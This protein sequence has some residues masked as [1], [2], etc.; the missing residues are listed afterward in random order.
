M[1]QESKSANFPQVYIIGPDALQNH[2][3]ALCIEKELA[4]ECQCFCDLTTMECVVTEPGRTCIL[5]LDCSGHDIAALDKKLETIAAMQTATF[6]SALFNL[7]PVSPI[8]KLVLKRRVRGIFYK[9]DS[10]KVFLKG[11]QTLINGQMWLSRKMMS[12]CALSSGNNDKTDDPSLKSLTHREK[13][14]LTLVAIGFSNKDIA[15]KMRI[16]VNTVT[17]HLFSAYKKIGVN[18]RLQATLWA[19]AHL[20]E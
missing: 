11:L 5:L 16:T 14:V 12:E 1:P 9:K 20:C 3:L 8:E 7:E 10:R 13:E 4:V 17:T 15:E 6:I 18:N 2:M 19:A